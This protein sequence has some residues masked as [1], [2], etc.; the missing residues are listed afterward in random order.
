M[1]MEV[2]MRIW[3]F[4]NIQ[5]LS[6]DVIIADP[7]WDFEN[8]SAAGTAKGADPHYSV[9]TLD[10]IKALPVGQLA[11]GDCLLLLW[12]CGWAMANGAAL[13]VARAWGFTPQSEIVWRKLTIDGEPRMGTGYRV[14][15]LHEPILLA[16]IGNPR[17][18]SFPSLF[19][20]VARE[21]S[22]KPDEFFDLVLDRTPTAMRRADLFS[23]ETRPGFEG[24]GNEHRKF[25]TTEAA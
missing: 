21:H 20:G 11:R 1:L 2:P 17:H 15:T 5:P 14:R 24:W 13:E 25:D 16:T 8:Y 22:R 18:K 4:E 23:R 10:A 12:T 7:P 3:P 9:M 19:D 6:C